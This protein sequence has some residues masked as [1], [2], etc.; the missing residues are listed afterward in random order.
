M[1][2]DNVRRISKLGGHYLK[3]LCNATG[4]L[5]YKGHLGVEVQGS[6]KCDDHENTAYRLR[7]KT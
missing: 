4:T 6:S 7:M 1:P 2:Q 5:T 3:R